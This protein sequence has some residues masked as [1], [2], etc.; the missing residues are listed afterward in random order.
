MIYLNGTES[1]NDIMRLYG[2][3]KT[4][5]WRAKKRGYVTERPYR[6]GDCT[7]A[8]KQRVVE[9]LKISILNKAGLTAISKRRIDE[10]TYK[11]LVPTKEEVVKFKSELTRIRNFIRKFIN[12]PTEARMLEFRDD[13]RIHHYL[14]FE[15]KAMQKVVHPECNV[16]DNELEAAKISASAFY[17]Q[18][19]F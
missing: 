3:T 8:E 18:L 2:L 19:N 13:T 10:I 7:P 11:N 6:I 12:H 14:L 4:T 1:T 17:N 9:I 15:R 16:N 5:A